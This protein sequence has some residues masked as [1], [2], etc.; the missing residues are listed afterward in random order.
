MMQTKGLGDV[1]EQMLTSI[2][3]TEERIKSWFKVKKCGCAKR[4]RMLNELFRKEGELCGFYLFF[5]C[6]L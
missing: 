4:K 5:Y 3:I 1:V 6:F 2:G